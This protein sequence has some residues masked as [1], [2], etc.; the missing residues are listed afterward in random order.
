M[1]CFWASLTLVIHWPRWYR[2]TGVQVSAWSI[3]IFVNSCPDVPQADTP[4]GFA[5]GMY[6]Q[7][8]VNEM[9]TFIVQRFQVPL[10]ATMSSPWLRGRLLACVGAGHCSISFHEQAESYQEIHLWWAF[11]RWVV[12]WSMSFQKLFFLHREIHCKEKQNTTSS[13]GRRNYFS[14]CT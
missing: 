12:T 8:I 1:K 2:K 13:G 6:V 9:W 10:R 14:L 4:I 11:L 7:M 5:K 3:L